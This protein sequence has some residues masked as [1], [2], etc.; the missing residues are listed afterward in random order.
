MQS[1]GFPE[2]GRA[3]MHR[4]RIRRRTGGGG[5]GR[6]S[7]GLTIPAMAVVAI[8]MLV[9]S[10][11]DTPVEPAPLPAPVPTTVTVGPGSAALNAIGETARFTAEVRDQNGQVMAG[12]AVAWTTS[13]ASVAAVDAS[14]Q[15]TAMANGTATI[16]A[17]AGSASGTAAVTVA[18]VVTAVALS[19]PADTLVALGDTVRLV[20]VATDANGHAVAAVTEFVWSSSD[21]LVVVV[22]SAGLLT[23]VGGGTTTVTAAASQVAGA[24]AVTVMQSAGSVVVSPAEGAI[25]A[26]DTLR[27]AAE[28]FDDNGHRVEGAEFAWG[29]SDAGVATVDDS[30]LVTAVAEGTAQITA[31]A[32]DVSGVAEITVENPD[33][34]ALVALYH[35]TDGA[36]WVDNTNWLTGGPLGEWHGVSV[37]AGGR[38]TRL[39]LLRNGLSGMIPPEIGDLTELQDLMLAEDPRLSGPIPSTLGNLH[40]LQ[41]LWLNYNRLSGPIPPELGNLVNLTVL[42]IGGNRLSGPVPRSFLELGA[43][44]R[45]WFGGQWGEG[46]D[47]CVPGRADFVAWLKGLGD[48]PGP[49]CNESDITVLESL[50]ERA[51]GSEW[52][53]AD[54]WLASAATGEW[55]G[56]RSDSLGRVQAIDLVGN[57]LSGR[58]PQSLGQLT[59]MTGLRIGDNPLSGRLPKSL[60]ELPLRELHY[61]GTDLCIPSDGTF[62]EWLRTIPSHEGT[63]VACAGLSEREILEALYDVTSG[64]SWIN[65]SGWLTDTPLGEWHGVSV[66]ADGGVTQ[67][68]LAENNLFGPIP[69]ELGGL[70]NLRALHLTGNALTG[71][72]PP[73]LGDLKGLGR[74]RLDDNALTGSIPP[75]LGGLASLW[76]LDLQENDLTGPIPPELDDLA[77]L[78]RLELSGNALTGSI[79]SELGGL[80]TLRRFSL[81][82]NDLTGPIPPELGGLT[83]LEQLSLGDNDLMGPIP[84]ELGKLPNLAVLELAD[85]D[86]TGPIPSQLTGLVNL[87]RLHLGGNR[88]TGAVPSEF[89]NLTDL[90]ELVL[91]NNPEMA[92]VLPADLTAL[93]QL[94]G[95]VTS[96]TG[97]CAPSDDAFRDWL[98]GIRRLQV[99]FC[100]SPSPSAM[101]LIQAVQSPESTV[102]LV[103][104]RQ[105]LLR[106]FVTAPQSTDVRVPPVRARFYVGDSEVHVANIAAKPALIPT[107]MKEGDL[108]ASSNAVIPGEVVRPG[109]EAVIEIDPEGTLDPALLGVVK[110]IPE[111]GRLALDVRAMPTLDLTLIPFLWSSAPDS[112]VV[113]RVRDMAASPEKHGMLWH[114]RTLL[115]VGDLDVTPHAPVL[116]STNDA[117]G[118]LDETELIRVME[119]GAGHY[120]GMMSGRIRGAGGVAIRYG[121]SA[122]STANLVGTLAHELGHNMSLWHAPCGAGGV[123]PAFPQDDGSIGA[124]GYDFRGGRL[125]RPEDP[126]LMSYCPPWWISGYH[127]TNAMRFRL[128]DEGGS[129]AEASA[130][131][132]R[133]LVLWG[134]SGPE[135]APHLEP[136]F[137][138]EAPASL[139]DSTGEYRIAGS[140]SAGDELFALSFAMHEV[141]HGDGRS[142]F[143]FALPVEPH[144]ADNL[145]SITL[146]GP[147]GS[148]ALDRDTNRPMAIMRDSR[149]GRVRAFVRDPAPATQAVADAAGPGA[150]RGMEVLF[151]R[152]IPSADVWQR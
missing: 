85:N 13:G 20:A 66:N 114:A 152:G 2:D 137:V 14:G 138:A 58:L 28:A 78:L 134:G 148:V 77:T 17:T 92:G 90:F 37:N 115:P 127:F 69:S 146:S 44:Q 24:V 36:Y 46:A 59:H 117:F 128:S 76:W 93:G 62:G 45:F 142:S 22:D 9:L 116:T 91:G 12:A 144:W 21:T 75:E 130:A 64:S 132:V 49:F 89:G 60:M 121:R 141:A 40:S 51:G 61:G 108:E 111:T 23:A 5:P 38:V 70:S 87:T 120:M 112:Q 97:L 106:V 18:Q 123:D 26:G 43:L 100:E 7:A 84:P 15:V 95:L 143:A 48:N 122:F 119:G 140:T 73:E 101:Y 81:Q 136:A 30:G 42:T 86:L 47:L 27:L 151:S 10:C 105:A 71:S 33:R 16:T 35:A 34:A 50:Y 54:G 11:G 31:T 32:G 150:G 124:W 39:R 52:V 6:P 88:L 53:E 29:S 118:L 4:W 104:G 139:P 145:A 19:P 57:G 147:G 1:R 55:H 109:L 94:D 103:A 8:A 68:F 96:G 25:G 125:V 56:V 129:G 74:L 72:I 149:T 131:P 83:D 133:S 98:R 113:D 102:P 107:E 63:G 82:E 79:P 99:E 80:A 135:G 41:S 67:L 3:R 65:S 126:D 110:R